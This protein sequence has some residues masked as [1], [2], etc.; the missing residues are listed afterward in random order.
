[1]W[2]SGFPWGLMPMDSKV[3]GVLS[4]QCLPEMK[5]TLKMQVE[6][7]SGRIEVDDESSGAVFAQCFFS[8]LGGLSCCTMTGLSSWMRNS[9]G[10][11]LFQGSLHRCPNNCGFSLC[12]RGW[13]TSFD[14]A[15]MFFAIW[16]PCVIAGSLRRLEAEE[17]DLHP[18]GRGSC[19]CM[20]SKWVVSCLLG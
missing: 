10:F 1:M 15:E 11:G 4:Q 19:R 17:C 8:I 13:W 12:G 18:E 3:L 2:L 7:E 6:S 9:P 20:D 5:R 14:V 16:L